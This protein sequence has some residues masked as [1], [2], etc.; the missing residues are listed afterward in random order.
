MLPVLNTTDA[1]YLEAFG[2]CKDEVMVFGHFE[3]IVDS[4]KLEKS[5]EMFKR[6]REHWSFRKPLIWYLETL[7]S[8]KWPSP[9]VCVLY[10]RGDRNKKCAIEDGKKDKQSALVE[11]RSC[12]AS[13][14]R[15]LD[16][17]LDAAKKFN[18]N[19]T[20]GSI[21][22]MQDTPIVEE[23]PKKIENVK[24]MHAGTLAEWLHKN[25]S[26]DVQKKSALFIAQVIEREICLDAALFVNNVFSP[27]GNLIVQVRKIRR[28]PNSY[29]GEPDE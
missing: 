16:Y 11:Y 26:L 6:M 14:R 19:I 17:A 24:V 18:I 8:K 22:V 9:L 27:L 10:S 5:Q 7:K 3:N 21:Y 20:K 28:L 4:F 15:I 29:L 1:Y 2:G 25:G 13:P 12:K 23:L